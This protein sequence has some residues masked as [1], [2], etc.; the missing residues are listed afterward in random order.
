MP[1]QV[2]Y[3][4]VYIEEVPSGVRAISGVS[5]STAVFIGLASYEKLHDL[6]SRSKSIP[7]RIFSYSEYEQEFGPPHLQS[8]LAMS[9]RLFFMNGGSECYVTNISDEATKATATIQDNTTDIIIIFEAK[10]RGRMGNH[11]SVEITD[12]NRRSNNFTVIVTFDNVIKERFKSCTMDAANENCVEK[13]IATSEFVTCSIIKN[14]LPP[15]GIFF[16]SDG[17]DTNLPQYEEVVTCYEEAIKS[18][19]A[20]DLFNLLVITKLES[21]PTSQR[22][23]RDS[24]Y[25]EILSK[26]S[27]YCKK[28]RAFLLVDP[29]E[30]WTKWDAP[31]NNPEPNILTLRT[32]VDAKNSAV[33]FP[34][35][36]VTE[37]DPATKKSAEKRIGP[38][39]AVAG[40][41][42]KVDSQRGVWKEPAG[43]N[44]KVIGI[45]ELDF[46]ITD[47]QNGV[48]NPQAINC[49]RFFSLGTVVWGARTITGYTDSEWKYIPVRRLALF[50]EETLY[51]ETKWVVFEPNEEPT[52]ALIRTGIGA[53]MRN[54]FNHGAFQGAT[55]K[56]A[57]F[58]KCDKDTNP[59]LD[60]RL[61]KFNIIVG[62]APLK[63]A[64]FVIIK[65]QQ[66]SSIT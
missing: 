18:L 21:N 7:R 66:I 34:Q 44:A 61:G 55:P 42:A 56:E 5:T 52:W 25:S 45:T 39:A 14:V 62:F 8:S 4:G 3:P 11:I 20:I 26:A 27:N 35:L 19:D 36:K 17:I 37:Y 16:L 2:S 63:P 12:S 54:L 65:I 13:K 32:K 58:V 28:R 64:E 46:Q 43:V 50:I 1:V 6:T 41:I 15:N 51:R 24:D 29:F 31:I 57:F 33:Y 23:M 47:Q 49:I 60:R 59:E 38:A 53:F 30:S 9:V 48:L 10:S 40:I 22:G